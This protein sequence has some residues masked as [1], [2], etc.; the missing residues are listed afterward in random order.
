MLSVR[1]RAIFGLTNGKKGEC[2]GNLFENNHY[3]LVL[4]KWPNSTFQF[5]FKGRIGAILL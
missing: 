2:S 4:Q 1:G 5:P 3:Y